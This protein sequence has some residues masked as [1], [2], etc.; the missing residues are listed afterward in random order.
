MRVNTKESHPSMWMDPAVHLLT[1]VAFH[2]SSV[3]LLPRRKRESRAHR[4]GHFCFLLSRKLR[5][6]IEYTIHSRYAFFFFFS[7]LELWI[8]SKK[9][10]VRL[11]K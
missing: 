4:R 8:P 7:F 1:R 10:Y 9:K 5:P 3:L 2:S 11:Y 6:D